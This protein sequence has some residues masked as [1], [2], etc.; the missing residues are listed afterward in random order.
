MWIAEI[1]FCVDNL[2]T[3][4]GP[5]RVAEAIRLRERMLIASIGVHHVELGHDV[6]KR[7]IDDLPWLG[8]RL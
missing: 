5:F 7:R 3:V 4:G 6:G 8:E 2:R 1:V